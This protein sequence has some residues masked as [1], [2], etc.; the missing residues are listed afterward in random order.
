VAFFTFTLTF[1]TILLWWSTAELAGEARDSAKKLLKIE[2][3]YVTGGGDFVRKTGVELFRLDVE[4]HGKT[5]AFMTA[6]DLQFAKLADLQEEERQKKK[7]R[8]LRE[9][10][11]RFRHIDGMSPTGG[12]K[13]IFTQIPLE[14]DADVVF[15]AVWY[16]DPILGDEHHSR[17]ILRIAPTRDIP[18]EGLTRLDVK[19]VSRDYWS[20]DYREH[21]EA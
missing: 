20:W 16:E 19:G 3:P 14:P 10:H 12:R 7:P 6:Y 9:K 17:F 15:G 1:S 4:N 5:P 21:M 8:P 18:G 13:E 2:P 11:C